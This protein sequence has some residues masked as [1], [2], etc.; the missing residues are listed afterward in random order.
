MH[1]CGVDDDVGL[2]SPILFQVW[3]TSIERYWVTSGLFRNFD[4]AQSAKTSYRYR[5]F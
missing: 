5:M 1:A 4:A 3:V 2:Q